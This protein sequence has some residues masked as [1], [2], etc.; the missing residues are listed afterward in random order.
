MY[1]LRKKFKLPD[2]AE[3]VIFF[4]TGICGL[5]FTAVG[6]F[7]WFFVAGLPYQDPTDEIQKQWLIANL[8]G[9]VF[10]LCGITAFVG[11]IVGELVLIY[12][13]KRRLTNE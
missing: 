1:L 5:I 2:T 4:I 11:G 13:K 9:D 12:C 10:F 7:Y 3:K 8:L 6:L